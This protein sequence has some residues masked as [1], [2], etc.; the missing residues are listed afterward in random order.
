ME[1]YVKSM[2]QFT[3]SLGRMKLPMELDGGGAG[4]VVQREEK[5]PDAEAKKDGARV[6]YGSRAFF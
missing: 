6:F 3:E 2:Q 1:M 5:K 4:V